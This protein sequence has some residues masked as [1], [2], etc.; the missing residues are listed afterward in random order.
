RTYYK[1]SN[2]GTQL[3]IIINYEFNVAN[4][5]SIT[6][7]IYMA[8]VFY[9]R[10][11]EYDGGHLSYITGKYDEFK[12]S[13]SEYNIGL[14]FNAF[15]EW[16]VSKKIRLLTG[17]QIPFYLLNPHKLDVSSQTHHP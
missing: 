11:Y 14:G 17:F 13:S 12:I 5:L 1:S 10:K 4:F 9:I 16:I 15:L 7:S 6:P 2:M 3:S 8:N